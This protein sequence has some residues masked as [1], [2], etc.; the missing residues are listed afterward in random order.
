MLRNKPGLL[1]YERHGR[2][3]EER[4]EFSFLPRVNGR[5]EDANDHGVL[6][7]RDLSASLRLRGA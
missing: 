3:L 4:L 2:L 5:P 7:A 1:G 6:L